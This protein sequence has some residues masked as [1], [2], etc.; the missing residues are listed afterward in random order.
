MFGFYSPFSGNFLCNYDKLPSAWENIRSGPFSVL[1]GMQEDFS[2]VRID[3]SNLYSSGVRANS[4]ID[5]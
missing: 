2:K 4:A 3:T 5:I 1:D